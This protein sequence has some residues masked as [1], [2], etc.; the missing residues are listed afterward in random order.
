MTAFCE[1]GTDWQQGT[2]LDVEDL[3]MNKELN[4]SPHV[5]INRNYN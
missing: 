4:P 5:N 2:N 1:S 3:S